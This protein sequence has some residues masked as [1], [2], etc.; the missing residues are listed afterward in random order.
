LQ[1]FSKVLE[2][3]GGILWTILLLLLL[4]SAFASGGFF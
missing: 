1:V 2:G 4:I 3:E